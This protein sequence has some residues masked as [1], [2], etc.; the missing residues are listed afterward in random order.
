MMYNLVTLDIYILHEILI[1]IYMKK[2]DLKNII[3]D[4]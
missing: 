3:Q 1:I 2:S 4:K